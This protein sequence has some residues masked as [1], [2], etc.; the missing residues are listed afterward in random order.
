MASAKCFHK[1]FENSKSSKN[2]RLENLALYSIYIYPVALAAIGSW[3]SS[4]TINTRRTRRTIKSR[5]ARDS[6]WTLYKK[7]ILKCLF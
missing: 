1:N 4:V 5:G 2:W 3:S 7:S 6:S